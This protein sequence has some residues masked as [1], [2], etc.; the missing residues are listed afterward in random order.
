MLDKD[1][2]ALL[3]AV[4]EACRGGGFKIVEEEDFVRAVPKEAIPRTLSLLEENHFIELR[5]AEEGTYCVRTMPEGIRYLELSKREQAERE[6]TRRDVFLG[7]FFGSAAGSA[8]VILLE[9]LRIVLR[10]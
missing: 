5:Y 3:A 9:L 6:R 7:A 8:A 2:T 4:N 10:V 1:A